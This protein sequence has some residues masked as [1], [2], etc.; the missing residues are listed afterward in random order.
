M[1]TRYLATIEGV[2]CAVPLRDYLSNLITHTQ[3]LV[4]RNMYAAVLTRKQWDKLREEYWATG[5]QC[6]HGRLVPDIDFLASDGK[7]FLDFEA[8]LLQVAL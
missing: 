6:D 5:R 1:T 3:Y 4:D 2:H 7:S 8:C